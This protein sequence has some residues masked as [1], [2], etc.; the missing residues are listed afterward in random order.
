MKWPAN[1]RG[2]VPLLISAF[3]AISA[4]AGA[5]VTY[6]AMNRVL[7]KKHQEQ[8]K[9]ELAQAREYYQELYSTPVF[10]REEET[11]EDRALLDDVR[12]AT[13]EGDGIPE[14]VVGRALSAVRNYQGE[15]EDREAVVIVPQDVAERPEPTI[16]NNIFVNHVAPGEEVLAALMADRDP[17][18]PYIITKEEFYQNDGD[19]DQEKFT[20]WEGDQ[21]LVND[22]EELQP[23]D[24]LER[25]V[26]IENLLRFGYGSGDEHVL[27]VRN[28]TIDPPL[29]LHITRST[30]KYAVE[31]MAIDDDGPHLAHSRGNRKF[32]TYDE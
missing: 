5:G 19:F 28:E 9:A 30:G 11:E 1:L 6:V 2:N 8:L 23:I 27:Y 31:V 32:R 15:D 17:S 3:S 10:V 21:V 4:A 26:G 25:V 13:D 12:E 16:V 7:E 22:K 20:Y 14:D 29:D 18:E 24:D